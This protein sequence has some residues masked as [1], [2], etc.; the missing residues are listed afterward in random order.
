M[1]FKAAAGGH[2][3]VVVGTVACAALVVAPTLITVAASEHPNLGMIVVVPVVVAGIVLGGVPATLIALLAVAMRGLEAAAGAVGVAQAVYEAAVFV[4][5]GL[6]GAAIR[7][8]HLRRVRLTLLVSPAVNTEVGADGPVAASPATNV[9][10]A[11]TGRPEV[12]PGLVAE[13]A[14]TVDEGCFAR[15]TAAL[16]P[17]QRQVVRLAIGGLTA[18]G[19]ASHLGIGERTVETHLAIAYERMNVHSRSELMARFT[20]AVSIAS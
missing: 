1:A 18:R 7:V 17:R 13:P 20:A 2:G 6:T 16:S 12:N 15:Q 14:A 19:I 4:A 11:V 9:A 10:D 3:A 5:A 8:A